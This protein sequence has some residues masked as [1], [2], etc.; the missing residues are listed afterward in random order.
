MAIGAENDPTRGM[1]ESTKTGMA[2][3]TKGNM[4]SGMKGCRNQ[5]SLSDV[6]D[7]S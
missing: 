4:E 3:I 7:G 2:G 5:G 6:L 1:T